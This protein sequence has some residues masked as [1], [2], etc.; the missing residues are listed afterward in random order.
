MSELLTIEDFA[1]HLSKTFRVR[2]GRHVLELAEIDE[3]V[4]VDR[5]RDL[6]KRAPFT[7]LFRGP[8]GDVLPA[9]LW[10]FD[11]D[12]ADKPYEL[13]VM[14]IHTHASDRQDYQAAFN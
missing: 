1:P 6:V 10:T 11:V 9:G 4:L 7:L 12:G 8:P 3:H 13:Y 2:D 5:D 14:P